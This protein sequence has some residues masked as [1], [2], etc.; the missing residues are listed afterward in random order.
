[1]T[2]PPHASAMTV[3]AVPVTAEAATNPAVS[4]TASAAAVADDE[5]MRVGQVGP[6]V[7]GAPTD[8]WWRRWPRRALLAAAALW[9]GFTTAHLLLS[10]RLWWWRLA[11]LLPPIAF[12]TIPVLLA[13]VAAGN[14]RAR[15]PVALLSL[16][17]L[18]LGAGLTGLNLPGPLRPAPP[19]PADAL[20]VVSWNTEYW[21]LPDRA[22]EFYDLLHAQRA[23]VYLL[24]EYLDEVDGE[25]VRADELDQVRRQF[26]GYHLAVVGELLTLSRYPIVAA[27]PL[28][29]TGLPSAPTDFT[30]FWNHQVLRTDLL[31]DGRVVSAYNAHLPVPLWAGGP[32]L[33]SG[34]FHEAIRTQHE[35]R[36]PQFRALA[37][38]V[39][40]NS[41]P[42]LVAG[43]LN[44]SPA[45]G[46][47][48]RFP[49]QLRDAGYASRSAYPV[50]WSAAG[51]SLLL[52]RLDWALVSDDV[53]VH[54]YEFRDPAGHS[55]HRLQ[56]LSISV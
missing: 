3:P 26:P 27:T 28:S 36:I 50:S 29:A 15:R 40:D 17:A 25:V 34:A 6:T 14:R 31:I 13:V 32:S 11:D 48:H 45:M 19:V 39:A 12:L 42:I 43:D 21:H 16:A 55:D 30:D 4:V 24:Q 2:A 5:P 44:T 37:A 46:D 1:M 20:R 10:G 51:P 35:R 33:F 54:R 9:L 41:H 7:A 53:E 49:P 8:R 47:T 23:D 22:T 38:D 52:W 18:L 56:F